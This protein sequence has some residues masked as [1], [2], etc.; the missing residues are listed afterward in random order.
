MIAY[1]GNKTELTD[2]EIIERAQKLGMVMK[3]NTLFPNMN[4]DKDTETTE[5]LENTE[6][7]EVAGNTESAENTEIPE[8][9]EI[10]VPTEKVENTE[11]SDNTEELEN[12]EVTEST[13]VYEST[14]TTES[15]E[16]PIGQESEVESYHLV[17]PP[18][19]IPRLICNELEENGVVESASELRQYLVDVGY[20]TSIVVGSYDIPYNSTNEEVY[21]I[22]KAGPK[23]R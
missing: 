19:G 7:T 21:Q 14:E 15:I 11:I 22:L 1:A 17:I 10:I 2:A 4:S 8:S 5:V 9:T 13:Q 16:E 18:G 20:I 3:E 6:S 23:N 12:S